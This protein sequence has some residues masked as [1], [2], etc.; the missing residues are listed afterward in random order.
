GLERKLIPI[1]NG[2]AGYKSIPIYVLINKVDQLVPEDNPSRAQFVTALTK[3]RAEL[4]KLQDPAR[5]ADALDYRESYEHP[6]VP[7]HL[8]ATFDVLAS[9]VVTPALALGFTNLV[10]QPACLFGPSK[11]MDAVEFIAQDLEDHL[12]PRTSAARRRAFT[13]HFWGEPGRV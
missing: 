11:S 6:A 2:R 8:A 13:A 1:E 12:L 3:C 4:R 5:F 10:L 9:A 7:F